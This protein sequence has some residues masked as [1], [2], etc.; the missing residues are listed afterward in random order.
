[1]LSNF[2]A[3]SSGLACKRHSVWAPLWANFLSQPSGHT[4]FRSAAQLLLH[5]SPILKSQLSLNHSAAR[6]R[7]E[8]IPDPNF[9]IRK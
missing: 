6:E 5:L 8:R 3:K 7:K 9:L 2:W 1:M 4:G